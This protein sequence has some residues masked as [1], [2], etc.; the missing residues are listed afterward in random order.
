MVQNKDLLL[1]PM[2]DEEL[3]GITGGDAEDQEM[4]QDCLHQCNI[5]YPNAK[6]M[7]L[8]CRMQCMHSYGYI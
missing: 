5:S 4:M 3:A 7:R 6:S 2:S 1:Q 8:N